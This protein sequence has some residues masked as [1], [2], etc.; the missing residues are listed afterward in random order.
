[1]L[2]ECDCGY[3]SGHDTGLTTGAAVAA[4]S[5]TESTVEPATGVVEMTVDERVV[6]HATPGDGTWIIAER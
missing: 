3:F 5:V 2:R 6:D 1:M 4:T